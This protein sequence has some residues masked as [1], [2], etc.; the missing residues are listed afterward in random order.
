MSLPSPSGRG[1][2]RAYTSQCLSNLKNDLREF[3]C[4]EIPSIRKYV[5]KRRL[6]SF[7]L[8]YFNSGACSVPLTSSL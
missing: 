3:R 6:Y 4:I 8:A 2:V 1:G 7:A 5:K